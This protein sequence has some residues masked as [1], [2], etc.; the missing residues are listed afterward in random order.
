MVELK[1]LGVTWDE[2]NPQPIVLLRHE[3]QLLPIVVGLAEAK[4][5]E[6]GCMERN[7]GRPMTHDLICNVLAGLDAKLKSVVI[8][9]LENETFYAC[10]NIE[11]S[12]DDGKVENVIRIDSRPSDGIATA[13]RMGCPIYAAEEVM[14]AAAKFVTIEEPPDDEP[15]DFA[16]GE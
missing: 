13:V 10:L 7:F 8:Y 1:V 9:K 16:E 6:D 4:A 3:N 15:E 11:Q 12:V 2:Q 14:E 5:I